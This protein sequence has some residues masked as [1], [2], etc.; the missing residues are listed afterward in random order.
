MASDRDLAKAALAVGVV[1]LFLPQ[2]NNQPVIIPPAITPPNDQKV[3]FRVGFQPASGGNTF[4]PT[5]GFT[6][7]MADH[8]GSDFLDY[9]PLKPQESAGGEVVKQTVSKI[10]MRGFFGNAKPDIPDSMLFVIVKQSPVAPPP[11]NSYVFPS[12]FI[13]VTGVP[14]FAFDNTVNGAINF[15][16]TLLHAPINGVSIGDKISVMLI[17]NSALGIQTEGYVEVYCTN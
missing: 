5:P 14:A 4:G 7:L 2:P 12:G 8:I 16:D 3:L 13:A 17:Y 10:G 9:N 1:G 6:T 11:V 15:F